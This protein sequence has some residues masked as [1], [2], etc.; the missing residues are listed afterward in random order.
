[1]SKED[2]IKVKSN[3]DVP[4]GLWLVKTKNGGYHVFNNWA[5]HEKFKTI[6]HYFEFDEEV[7][8]YWD[9]PLPMSEA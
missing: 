6:G 1:M 7:D 2:W 5:T 4:K 9:K 8:Q 3:D